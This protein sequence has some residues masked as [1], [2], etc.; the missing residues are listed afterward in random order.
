MTMPPDKK[1]GGVCGVCGVS[2]PDGVCQC[3]SSTIQRDMKIGCLIYADAENEDK[4]SAFL[5]MGTWAANSF[6]HFHPDIE[7]I[8]GTFWHLGGTHNNLRSDSL[9]KNLNERCPETYKWHRDTYDHPNRIWNRWGINKFKIAE[10][11]IRTE[12]FDKVIVLG[13]D[14]ITCARLIHFLR[15]Y[16]CFSCGHTDVDVI[17]TPDINPRFL[18]NPDVIC[19]NAKKTAEG[20]R[21]KALTI[22]IAQWE[23]DFKVGGVE[24]MKYG[25][26]WSLKEA[27]RTQPPSS[28]Y[29][30][31]LPI[32]NAR[33]SHNA[34]KQI[35]VWVGKDFEL[36]NDLGTNQVRKL[37]V[38]HIQA[39]IGT[40]KTSKKINSH[41]TK[42]MYTAP[43]FNTGREFKGTE[44]REFFKTITGDKDMFKRIT[45]FSIV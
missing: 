11:L 38:Y 13:A 25:E 14:T 45:R 21:S 16:A 7:L 12:E 22:I 40:M 32:D 41:L 27:L 5:R 15:E 2:G 1:V 43:I 34:N 28:N 4:M 20:M 35:D 18:A 6:A 8:A 36:I 33:Y 31:R 10:E 29:I 3:P 23:K 26:M 42:Y 24:E 9:F 17:T 44:N 30:K 39:G 37:F 19:F